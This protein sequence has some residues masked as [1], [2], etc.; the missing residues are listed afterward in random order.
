MERMFDTDSFKDE[1]VDKATAK[2]CVEY[3]AK[4]EIGFRK[5]LYDEGLSYEDI[6]EEVKKVWQN[7]L[8]ACAKVGY[9]D[10]I[11]KAKQQQYGAQ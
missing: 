2:A 7:L 3:L 5:E 4:N 1:V 6:N 9:S 8:K 10:Y 11:T